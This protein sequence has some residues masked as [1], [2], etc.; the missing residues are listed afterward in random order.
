MKRNSLFYT[1]VLAG[2]LLACQKE[3]TLKPLHMANPFAPQP[4]ATDE[5]SKLREEFYKNTGCHLLFNDTL[6]P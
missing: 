4:G 5:E 2:S 1:I 3:D 6:R